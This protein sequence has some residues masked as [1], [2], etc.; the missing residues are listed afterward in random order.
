MG[1]R[2]W[3]PEPR[4]DPGAPRHGHVRGE[5]VLH[6]GGWRSAG[7]LCLRR[8]LRRA[9]PAGGT[10]ADGAS[11]A[12]GQGALRAV[13]AVA[14]GAAARSAARGAGA[15][16]PVAGDPGDRLMSVTQKTLTIF[17]A[18]APSA[19]EH[20]STAMRLAR[21]ALDAGH[22]GNVFAS[23]DGVYGFAVGGRAKGGPGA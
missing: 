22:R 21:A 3:A 2:A 11:V 14:A 13:V 5:R 1:R 20:A 15:G 6:A 23:A 16:C 9:Q 7:G 10:A 17:L 12:L 4:R 19:G 18:A 8:L